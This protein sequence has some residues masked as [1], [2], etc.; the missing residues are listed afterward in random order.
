MPS[1]VIN[2]PVFDAD[3]HMYETVDAFT[4]FLPKEYEGLV[5]YVTVNGRTKLALR[6]VISDYIPNPT[7]EVV[8]KPGAQEEYFKKGNPEGKSRR[9]IMGEP[10]RS[11]E[12]FFSPEPRLALMNE[13]GVDRALMWPT[14]ASLLEERLRNDPLAT[15]AVI[16][17]LNQWMHEHWTFNYENRIF[18]TPVITLPVVEQAIK[19]LEWVVER[20]AKIVLIRP[21]PV[22]GFSGERSFALPEFDPFWR[23][24]IEAD[25]AVGLHA[26]DDG[27]MRYL[28]R[29]EGGGDNE[30]LP[31]AGPSAFADILHYQSR[32]IYDCVASMIGHGLLSRFPSLRMLPVENGSGWVR[33]L[34]EAL[35]HSY[36][37]NPRF[38][39]E[40]PVK[41]LKRNVWVHPFHEEDPHGLIKLVGADRVVFGSDFPHPEGLAQ[42]T[43]YVDELKGLADEDIAR[44]MGAN[45][46]EVIRPDLAA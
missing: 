10:M 45:L 14:L 17:A 16:H 43:S 28:N 46:T 20:G 1:P 25:I 12:A 3:N 11:P 15:H 35:E 23:R 32:G 39:S 5:K 33:P 26:S 2:F 7:F 36:S 40:D 44:I 29:W 21:A 8:A 30:F 38:Y 4:K 13:L 24:V 6:N 42:P 41:V 9:E 31:F 34:V 19:E 37:A 27:Q 22:P 18:P